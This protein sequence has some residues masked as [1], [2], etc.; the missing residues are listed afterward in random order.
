MF[1]EPNWT[2]S[3][4]CSDCLE[5]LRLNQWKKFEENVAKADC[6]AALLR[7]CQSVPRT[8]H[9]SSLVCSVHGE[10]CEAKGAISRLWR[11]ETDSDTEPILEGAKL[12]GST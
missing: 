5:Y 6:R 2:P 12:V 3:K 1:I 11:K 9:E 8:L 7:L 4:I 10:D